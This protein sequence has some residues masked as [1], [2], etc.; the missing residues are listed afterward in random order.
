MLFSL[1]SW[2]S[3]FLVPIQIVLFI[4]IYQMANSKAK[5]HEKQPHFIRLALRLA[6]I[7]AIQSLSFAHI[8]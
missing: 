8:L 6:A 5:R 1:P 3:G 7:W 4:N 2:S